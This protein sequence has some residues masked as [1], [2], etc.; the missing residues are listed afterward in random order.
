MKYNDIILETIPAMWAIGVH[1]VLD[2][3]QKFPPLESVRTI[4]IKKNNGLSLPLFLHTFEQFF[5]CMIPLIFRLPLPNP[6]LCQQL[7]M[8]SIFAGLVSCRNKG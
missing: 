5:I 4:L 7:A 1:N 8:F 3:F 2:T 6:S